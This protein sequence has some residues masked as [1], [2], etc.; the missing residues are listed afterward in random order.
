[1]L[2]DRV[3]RRHRR[4]RLAVLPPLEARACVGIGED[5]AEVRVAVL[6]LAEQRHVCPAF[7]AHLGAGD[8]ADAEVLCRVCELERAVHAVVVGERERVVAELGGARRKL[9]R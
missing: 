4:R 2:R 8:R 5:A 7:E 3:E 1:M 9:L 6:R